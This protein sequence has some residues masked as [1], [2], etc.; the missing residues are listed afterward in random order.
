MLLDGQPVAEGELVVRVGDWERSTRITV[1]DGAFM[2]GDDG[3]LLVS[4]PNYSYVD[5]PVTFH[6]NAEQQA[7]LTY[8]FPHLSTPCFVDHVE[9]RFGESTEFRTEVPCL[10]VGRG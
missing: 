9:L 2:C 6:L 7:D 1:R 3:C 5:E 8:P 10:G 4:P